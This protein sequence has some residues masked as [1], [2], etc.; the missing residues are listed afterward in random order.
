MNLLFG[1]LDFFEV[2]NYSSYWKSKYR[3]T[4]HQIENSIIL[5]IFLFLFLVIIQVIMSLVNLEF[6]VLETI[7]F[8]VCLR[9]LNYFIRQDFKNFMVKAEI[10]GYFVLHELLIVL[11]TSKSL[12]DATKFIMSS[13]YQIY[14][15]IFRASLIKS[16]F[17]YPLKETL[18]VQ[19]KN[20]ISGELRRIFL[21]VIDT[22]DIGTETTQFST[23]MVLSHLSE[24]IREE[25]DKVDTWGS[26]FSGITFLSPPVIL[27]F[28]LISGQINNIIGFGLISLVFVASIIFRPEKQLSV[29]AGHSPLLPFTDDRTVEFLMI[30]AE[31]LLSGLSYKKS[32]NK[33]LN[34]YVENSTEG[35]TS[36]VK[37]ALVSFRLCADPT[38]F[39]DFEAFQNF[40]SSRTLQILALVEK[41]SSISTRIAGSKLLMITE[42]MN[43][44]G[45][46][47]RIGKA[48]LKATAFQTA[49]IQFFALI[50]LAFI[51]GASPLFQLISISVWGYSGNANKAVNFDAIFIFLG[52]L[53]SMLPIYFDF[54]L[55]HRLKSSSAI[56]V[57]IT[58]F[59]LFLIVFIV[60]REFLNGSF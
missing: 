22:W 55:E 13:N 31:N 21:N 52:F 47:L 24:Y 11:E 30:H 18:R 32:L 28:L 46:L 42:E 54:N 14:S 25:T 40:F 27:C 20:Q 1:T 6:L 4:R 9:L 17:G 35:L 57:R 56:I 49:I 5:L 26:L 19:I 16:H 50:S 53:M 8:F 7:C 58:R 36:S 10:L 48:R 51:S 33:A 43:K 39:T 38:S 15:D 37:D 23:S 29:F 2:L 45:N 41:F 60:T 12:K 59:I 34:L 44:T 3:T